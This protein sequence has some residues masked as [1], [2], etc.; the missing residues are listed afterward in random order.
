MGEDK[1]NQ[2]EPGKVKRFIGKF[3]FLSFV[4]AGTHQTMELDSA[5]L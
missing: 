5:H 4:V 3:D 1:N 2:N